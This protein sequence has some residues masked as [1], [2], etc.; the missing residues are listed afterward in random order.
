MI[1]GIFL[2]VFFIIFTLFSKRRKDKPV[3]YLQL[4]ALF[5]TLH[6]LQ[7]YF[8]IDNIDT[9]IFA[10]K[11][12]LPWYVLI[13]PAFYSFVLY[14]L[15]LENKKK[16]YFQI[17][18]ALFGV[19]VL[20][21]I[22]LIPTHFH[23]VKNLKIANYAQFE[24]ILNAGF[25]IFLF[26]KTFLLYKQKSKKLDFILSFDKLRWLN[27]FMILAIVVILTWVFA[28]IFNL[29][30]VLNP[31]VDLYYPLRLSTTFLLCW[32][33]YIGFFRYNLIVDRQEIREIFAETIVDD[34]FNQTNDV[35][36]L[37]K[38]FLKIK[39]FIYLEK[40]YLNPNLMLD[41]VANKLNINTRNITTI[42]KVN[43][44]LNFSDYVNNFRVEKAKKCLL[45][46]NF[47]DYTIVTIGLECG[48]NSK[49]TFYRVFSK[50]V[51]KTPTQY[52]RENG[53]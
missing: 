41:D 6:N 10:Q 42:L 7:I 30:N 3:V 26:V 40:N 48:F 2:G 15:K 49:S 22:G 17:A 45:D 35:T 38:D 20:V 4:V 43:N 13:I 34:T 12:L 9:N 11:L 52:Q 37:D 5:L 27:Q 24:E 16:K 21:R 14:Y 32:I 19:E 29:K 25:T 36:V 50:Q 18:L 1:L 47:K 39:N 44:I 46:T 28:I 53:K 31:D 23:D 8:S 51:G 33:A